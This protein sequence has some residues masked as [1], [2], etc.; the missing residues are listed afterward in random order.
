MVKRIK[1][2]GYEAVKKAISENSNS[3]ALFVLFS[4]SKDA[5]GQSWCPDC[6]TADPIIE[7]GLQSAPEDSVFIYCGVGSRDYWKNP[8]NDF[9]KDEKFKLTSVPTLMKWNTARRLDDDQCKSAALVT[10]LFE[11]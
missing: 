6:V 1:V 9:R 11:D 10:M 4:G 3:N 7:E 5:N 8:N 2:E